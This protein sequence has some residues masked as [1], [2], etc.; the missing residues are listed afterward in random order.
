MLA[1]VTVILVPMI[2]TMRYPQWKVNN[3]A[4]GVAIAL[5]VLYTLCCGAPPVKALGKIVS[6]LLGSIIVAMGFGMNLM[7]VVKIGTTGLIYTTIGIS[8]TLALGIW[9]GRRLKIEE[10]TTLLTSIGTAICGGSAIAAAAPVLKA[11][12]HEI[13]FATATIFILNAL[14]LILFPILGHALDFDQTQFGTWAALT[15]HDTSSVVGTTMAYGEE[16]WAVGVT[17]KL[18]RALWIVPV[19]LML[20]IWISS[21]HADPNDTHRHVRAKVPW[22]IPWFLVGAAIFTFV[23][24]LTPEPVGAWIL[25]ISSTLKLISKSLLILALFWIGAGISIEKVKQVGI[26][27]FLHGTILWAVIATLWCIAIK[28]GIA[29]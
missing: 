3:Y 24:Q 10:H 13:A 11:K 1:S 25:H 23:P 5:G 22:F 2:L 29:G 16:A 17:L 14:A 27:P 12:A 28:I 4:P 18:L 7:E 26:R 8:G 19:T 21:R 9:V 6:Y 15:V 20:S